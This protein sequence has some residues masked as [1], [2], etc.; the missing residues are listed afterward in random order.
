M[1]QLFLD[2]VVGVLNI[3]RLSKLKFHDTAGVSKFV[4]VYYSIVIVLNVL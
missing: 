2:T 3:Y 4:L 1:S